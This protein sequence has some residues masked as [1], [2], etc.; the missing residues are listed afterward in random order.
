M[1]HI[2]SENALWLLKQSDSFPDKM[3]SLFD[4]FCYQKDQ[5]LQDPF[6]ALM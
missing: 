1:K 2:K 6:G 3:A 4:S 5:S